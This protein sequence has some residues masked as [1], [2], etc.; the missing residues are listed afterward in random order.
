MGVAGDPVE[1]G[2]GI[3]HVVEQEQIRAVPSLPQCELAHA[4]GVQLLAQLAILLAEVVGEGVAVVAGEVEEVEQIEQAGRPGVLTVDLAG[5]QG[6]VGQHLV[7]L[8]EQGAKAALHCR[9]L[10]LTV[11]GDAP[12]PHDGTYLVAGLLREEQRMGAERRQRLG[13]RLGGGRAVFLVLAVVV[14]IVGTHVFQQQLHGRMS[15]LIGRQQAL[16]AAGHGQQLAVIVTIVLLPD[17]RE[18]ATGILHYPGRFGVQQLGAR[19]IRLGTGAAVGTAT[20]ELLFLAGQHDGA[21]E[22]PA[23]L[24]LGCFRQGLPFAAPHRVLIAGVFEHHLHLAAGG[25]GLAAYPVADGL[26]ALLPVLGFIALLLCLGLVQLPAVLAPDVQLAHLTGGLAACDGLQAEEDLLELAIPFVG[27]LFQHLQ[28]LPVSGLVLPCLIGTATF[29]VELAAIQLLL[30]VTQDDPLR[31]RQTILTRRG[32]GACQWLPAAL[33]H[34]V[35]K[36]IAAGRDGLAGRHHLFTAE[37]ADLPAL[38]DL[39]LRFT[40]LPLCQGR[41]VGLAPVEAAIHPQLLIGGVGA[42]GAQLVGHF[43]ETIPQL[44]AGFAHELIL[45]PVGGVAGQRRGGE[46]AG[47]CQEQQPGREVIHHDPFGG[48][49]DVGTRQ[50]IGLQKNINAPDGAEEP[51]IREETT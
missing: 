1:A 26:V 9:A 12:G 5:M 36:V 20:V 42:A 25:Q 13:Q 34:A 7:E 24:P 8:A 10:E 23:L 19:Q 49:S 47:G 11:Q 6:G 41:Q 31:Q 2:V 46:Q 38:L 29:G 27:G 45:L 35:A 40:T 16:D 48:W 21:V 14:V 43:G 50:G 51:C 33:L 17:R 15:R 32:R 18:L 4:E 28:L 39:E 44:T 30:A 37:V 3:Q 22:H